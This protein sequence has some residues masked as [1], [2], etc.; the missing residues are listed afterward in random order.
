M[1]KPR[2][3]VVQPHKTKSRKG[4]KRS[5]SASS[6]GSVASIVIRE[7]SQGKRHHKH[8]AHPARS[9]ET[10]VLS[11]YRAANLHPFSSAAMGARVPDLFS[12]PTVPFTVTTSFTLTT[13]AN[14]DASCVVTPIPWMTVINPIGGATTIS[15]LTNSYTN[16]SG[17]VFALS[18][19]TFDQLS[20]RYVGYRLVGGGIIATNLLTPLTCTG[21]VI[22]APLPVIGANPAPGGISAS[23]DYRAM[24]ILTEMTGQFTGGTANIQLPNSM[25][26][27]P[28]AVQVPLQELIG[29]GIQSNFSVNS[30]GA[31]NFHSLALAEQGGAPTGIP[32][33][34]GPNQFITGG[35]NYFN[36]VSYSYS[37]ASTSTTDHR[38]FDLKC[39]KVMG[40]PATVKALEVKVT[41]HLEALPYMETSPNTGNNRFLAADSIPSPVNLAGHLAALQEFSSSPAM[42]LVT[43]LVGT[44][45]RGLA[46]G[47]RS[48]GGSLAGSLARLAIE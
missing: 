34:W 39:I 44:A 2:V 28:C 16:A 7:P 19:V 30:P 43:N 47:S 12:Y 35:D 23:N 48:H 32:G 15:G 13:D 27:L 25:V 26:A 41:Y 5:T 20:A 9:N 22:M 31:F 11:T 18:T 40:A 3:L 46:R 42:S 14:G 45:L 33:M 17:T 38:G 24:R 8:T 36:G 1:P 10:K 29:K 6:R 21:D 4:R 37:T